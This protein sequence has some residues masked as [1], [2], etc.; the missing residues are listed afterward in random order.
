MTFINKFESLDEELL[1]QYHELLGEEGLTQS[2]D[3]FARLMPEYI[4]ELERFALAEEEDDFRRQAHKVKGG[5]RS[6]GFARL[7]ALMQYLEKDHWQWPEVPALIADARQ[8]LA[9]DQET[10]RQW[11]KAKS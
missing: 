8:W 3:T 9:E 7:G 11:L 5:C 10:A 2:L 6:L 4:V 1:S